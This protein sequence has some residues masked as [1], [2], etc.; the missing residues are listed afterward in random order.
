MSVSHVYFFI[1][2]NIHFSMFITGC[3]GYNHSRFREII[4]ICGVIYGI[5]SLFYRSNPVASRSSVTGLDGSLSISKEGFL[6]WY[7]QNQSKYMI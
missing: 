3:A 2:D 7:V 1:S 5:N 4:I 6:Y